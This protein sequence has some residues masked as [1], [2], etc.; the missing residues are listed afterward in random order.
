MDD[1]IILA[2]LQGK[3]TIATYQ[4][5]EENTVKWLCLDVDVSK[6]KKG[7]EAV[8]ISW[9]KAHAWA[10]LAKIHELFGEHAA[11]LEFSGSRGYHIW[12][13]FKPFIQARH[14]YALAAWL[15]GQVEAPTGIHVDIFPRQTAIKSY[16]SMVKVPL[17]VHKKTGNRCFFVDPSSFKPYENQWY[18]LTGHKRFTEAQVLAIMEKHAIEA[19]KMIRID[20]NIDSPGAGSLPCISNMMAEG[21][22]EGARDLGM[23]YIATWMKRRDIPHDVASA[24][25]HQVN[26]K[27]EPPL[28]E[29]T[30]DKSILSAY[31]SD[32]SEFP[33]MKSELDHYCSS[34]CKFWKNKERERWTR[35]GRKGDAKGVISRS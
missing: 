29:A 10:L 33:C 7:E 27:S 24:A 25:I 1:D 3:E 2:H 13:F 15:E 4:L 17:G 30:L 6:P 16:G 31:N 12:M 8:D 14:A 5:T 18:A 21:I 28:D 26:M 20:R 9:V 19:P 35:R 11:A 34:S 22:T 32:Y 23:L